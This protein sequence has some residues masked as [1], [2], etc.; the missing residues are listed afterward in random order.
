M[1]IDYFFISISVVLLILGLVG[2]FLPIIPGP[3][4]AWLSLLIIKFS[5]FSV[6]QWRTILIAAF[7]TILVTV[8]DYFLPVWV[9]KRMG[10]TKGG[11][12]G[13]TIGTVVGIIF[14][15]PFGVIVGPFLGAYLG[16]VMVIKNKN[17][18]NPLRSA[19]GSFL[20]FLLG[21]ELKLVT[22]GIIIYLFIKSLSFGS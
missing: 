5:S 17:K 11:I 13:T 20:G 15:G 9:T 21:T 14:W 19:F 18:N 8:L 3:P 2:C 16:E 6:I 1:F 12:W 22:T 4:L 10:G 7:F